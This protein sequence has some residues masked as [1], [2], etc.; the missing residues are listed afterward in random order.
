MTGGKLQI[1]FDGT[2]SDLNGTTAS[3]TNLFRQPAPTG[4][5]WTA[6]TKLDMTDAKMQ[7]NQVGFVLW[8]A[9][10][11]GV[12]RFAKVVVNARTTDAS[13]PSRPSWWVER[14][15][16][17]NSST[18]GLGNGNAGYIAGAVPDTVFLRLVSSGGAVQTFRT[19]YSLDGIAW[20]EFL[21]AVHDGHDDDPAAGRRRHVPRGEQRQ[22]VRALRLVPRV[23]L[24]AGRHGAAVQRV[25]R[26]RRGRR[27]LAH[28]SRRSR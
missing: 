22:R 21:T 26:A 9:E 6:T 5:P 15:V 3:A 4:G 28:G 17:A 14:S 25:G 2:N 11:S 27:R 23:R 24:L 1:R 20:T 8:Q 18:T 13:A 16:T 10:G 19:Y 7:S 12:N